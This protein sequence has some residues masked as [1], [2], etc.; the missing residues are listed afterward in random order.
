M[1]SIKFDNFKKSNQRSNKDNDAIYIDIHLDLEYDSKGLI[2]NKEDESIIDNNLRRVNNRDLR[3][4]PD[5]LAIKNSLVNLFNTIPGQ[6]ILLPEYGTNLLGML[7]EG[8]TKY[9]GKVLGNH[10]LHA[11]ERWEPRVE[12]IKVRVIAEP[13]AHQYTLILALFIPA[14]N[15]SS[16]LIGVI[17]NEGFIETNNSE[18][19]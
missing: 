12:V 15:K 10:V 13:D 19:I 3:I 5:E 9:K 6:R 7:F 14:L 17:N 16:S 1:S 8:V 2:V 4:S 18:Y 11:I